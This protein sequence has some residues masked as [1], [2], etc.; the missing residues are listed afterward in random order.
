M[1]WFPILKGTSLDSLPK[2]K[3][4]FCHVWKTLKNRKM[5]QHSKLPVSIELKVLKVPTYFD[6]ALMQANFEI[7]FRELL[8]KL[9]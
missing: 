9:D 7:I 3:V 4:R 1:D 8:E 6:A 2:I 5:V